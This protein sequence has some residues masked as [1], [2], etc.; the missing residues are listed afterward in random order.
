MEGKG[1]DD[2]RKKKDDGLGGRGLR[3]L[4]SHKSYLTSQSNLRPRKGQ[5]APISLT[6]RFKHRNRNRNKQ[7]AK[8][9]V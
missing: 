6:S 5:Y 1:A 3:V 2:G 7:D 8:I 4:T 9:E